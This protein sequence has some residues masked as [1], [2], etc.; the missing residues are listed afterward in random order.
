MRYIATGLA[1]AVL[2]A[3][4]AAAAEPEFWTTPAIAGYGRMHPLPQAAYRP[5][6]GSRYKIVFDLTAAAKNP[7]DV[8]PALDRVAKTVNLY[9][10]SG[11]P[12]SHLKFVAVAHGPATALALDDEHYRA[13]FG[14]ANP[15][16]PLIAALRKAGV[17]VAVCGQAV[18]ELK[19]D[20]AWLDKSVTLSLSALT[21]ITTLESAG[22]VL[23][24]L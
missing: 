11:V 14:V 8:N 9:V 6:A 1:V 22:Y 3:T 15:N 16:L 2:V 20:Y 13:L 24:P 18:A 5:D 7:A 21:T 19:Y 10:A 4:A 17:D 12:L 23:L